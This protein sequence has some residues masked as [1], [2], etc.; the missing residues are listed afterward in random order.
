M[1]YPRVGVSGDES[2]AQILSTSMPCSFLLDTGILSDSL[3]FDR[4]LE[5]FMPNTLLEAL[6]R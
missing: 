4:E 2:E 1:F 3:L 5:G 6:S